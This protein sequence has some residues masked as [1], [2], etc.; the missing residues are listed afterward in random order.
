MTT[1]PFGR[2]EDLFAPIASPPAAVTDEF[3]SED[4]AQTDARNI[5]LMTQEPSTGVPVEVPAKDQGPSYASLPNADRVVFLLAVS[6]ALATMAEE[7][8]QILI[9]RLQGATENRPLPTAFGNLTLSP[10]SRSKQVDEEALLDFVR[11]NHPDKVV[12]RTVEEVDPVFRDELVAKTIDVG[13]GEFA[14]MDTGETVSWIHLSKPKAASISWPA[15]KSQK[16]AK[17]G[18]RLAVRQNLDALA[19]ALELT[20]GQ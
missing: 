1:V 7:E 16:A 17:A 4:D 13:D 6:D 15:S 8:K 9:E 14:N 2:E 18:A 11:E 5:H 12:T 20:D 19:E 3:V 10:E